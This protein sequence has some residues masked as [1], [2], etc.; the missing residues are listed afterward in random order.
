MTPLQRK[1]LNQLITL[2]KNGVAPNTKKHKTLYANIRNHFGSWGNALKVANLR[3]YIR[4]KSDEELLQELRD[5]SING[6]APR[7]NDDPKFGHVVI[8]R[9]GSWSKAVKKAKLKLAPRHP[10]L[11][12]RKKKYLKELISR[13]TNGVAPKSNEDL[14]LRINIVRHFGSWEAALKIAKLKPFMDKKL[15]T[16]KLLNELKDHSVNGYAP[17]ITAIPILGSSLQ[18]YFGSYKEAVKV[19]NLKPY[20]RQHDPVIRQQCLDE[21]RN[22]FKNGKPP[23]TSDDFNLYNRTKRLFGSWWTAIAKVN[24]TLQQ[25]NI[26]LFISLLALAV[27]KEITPDIEHIIESIR[28]GKVFYEDL[29]HLITL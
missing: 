12:E 24:P 2:S 25:P 16:K 15:I 20:S 18:Y 10:S 27:D 28:N 5:R 4:Q 22:K 8:R 21:I 13:S 23:K 26:K 9:F 3:P 7:H 19:A 11:K 1:Y 29:E 6:V 14:K 17:S